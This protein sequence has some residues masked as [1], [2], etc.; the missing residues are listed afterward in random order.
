[1][2]VTKTDGEMMRL[3]L[4]AYLSRAPDLEN[5]KE[6]A[7][8]SNAVPRIEDSQLRI[9]S[10]LLEARDSKL[11]LARSIIDT[12]AVLVFQLAYLEGIPGEPWVVSRLGE[13]VFHLET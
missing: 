6:A 13:E 1:V 10:W 12:P 5:E 9:G 4:I 7:R 8:L 2:D 3:A 11:V